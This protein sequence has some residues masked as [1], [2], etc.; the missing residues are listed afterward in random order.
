MGMD[1]LVIRAF[2]SSREIALPS[3]KPSEKTKMEQDTTM[4]EAPRGDRR[5]L[6]RHAAHLHGRADAVV[7]ARFIPSALTSSSRW[8]SATGSRF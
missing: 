5:A 3:S 4:L 1:R 7:K 6:G 8:A 2:N